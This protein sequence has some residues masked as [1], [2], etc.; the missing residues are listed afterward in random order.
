MTSTSKIGLIKK[1]LWPK[2]SSP[3]NLIWTCLWRCCWLPRYGR[4]QRLGLRSKAGQNV[5]V[6]KSNNSWAQNHHHLDFKIRFSFGEKPKYFNAIRQD[7]WYGRSA[8]SAGARFEGWASII[9]D[10]SVFRLFFQTGAG[11]KINVPHRFAVKTYHRFT[12]CDHCGSLLYGLIRQGL[13]CEVRNTFFTAVRR[14]I[15]GVL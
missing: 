6:K 5:F 13:Q 15:R 8:C 2:P 14:S 7:S 10:M 9:S 4:V 1:C 11:F 3:M 12:F